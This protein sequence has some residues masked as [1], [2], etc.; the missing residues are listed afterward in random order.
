MLRSGLVRFGGALLSRM[1]ACGALP[2]AVGPVYSN[3]AVVAKTHTQDRSGPID[4][5]VGARGVNT[6]EY[7]RFKTYM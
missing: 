7:V 6:I 5:G 2:A 1:L 4:R 3:P